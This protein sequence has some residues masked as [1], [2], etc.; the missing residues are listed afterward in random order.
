LKRLLFALLGTGH[1]QVV[2]AGSIRRANQQLSIR[3]SSA[4]TTDFQQFEF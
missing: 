3:I 4:I 2:K 1:F